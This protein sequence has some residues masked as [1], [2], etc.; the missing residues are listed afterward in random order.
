MHPSTQ[1]SPHITRKYS[2][3]SSLMAATPTPYPALFP[4]RE[5]PAPATHWKP[6]GLF[7]RWPEKSIAAINGQPLEGSRAC[8]EQQ[9]QDNYR[10]FNQDSAN[11]TS[12]EIIID[13]M[14][15]G[16]GILLS[17][18]INQPVCLENSVR[19]FEECFFNNQR[20]PIRIAWGWLNH[21]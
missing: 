21:L 13:D 9:G 3:A 7:W 6:R 8:P 10:P 14:C 17:I 16:T 12:K 18:R 2:N 11:Y 4:L 5:P 1:P 20:K 19:F 15:G